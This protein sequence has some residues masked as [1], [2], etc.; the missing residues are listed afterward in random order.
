[1][2]KE[3]QAEMREQAER[4]DRERIAKE[5]QE[6]EKGQSS[7]GIKQEKKSELELLL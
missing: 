2:S 7:F 3:K 5:A 1:M 6:A 4:E